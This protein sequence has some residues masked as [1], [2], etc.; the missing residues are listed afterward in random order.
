MKSL[1]SILL[2]AA[3]IAAHAEIRGGGEYVP[4]GDFPAVASSNVLGGWHSVGT[5]AERDSIS[6]YLRRVGMAVYVANNSTLYVLN[7]DLTNWTAFSSGATNATLLTVGGTNITTNAQFKF[8]LVGPGTNTSTTATATGAT[9]TA[10]M[11]AKGAMKAMFIAKVKMVAAVVAAVI[12][13]GTAVPVGIAVAQAVGKEAKL[14]ESG[15]SRRMAVTGDYL[16]IDLS[17][18]PSAWY[19]RTRM[20]SCSCRPCSMMWLLAR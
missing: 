2:A 3:T 14:A 9:T 16:V 4:A 11:L 10:A 18:G 13:T 12:V 1:I 15:D 6:N 19:F 20:T 5:T 8:A 17:G 7:A